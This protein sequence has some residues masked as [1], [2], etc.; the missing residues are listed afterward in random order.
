MAEFDADIQEK[1]ITNMALDLLMFAAL[2]I[3]ILLGFPV[4]FTIA[5]IAI[6]FAFIG[7]ISGLFDLS[8]LGALA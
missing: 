1:S 2:V 5:G 8:L 7:S 6:I 4:S 3:A